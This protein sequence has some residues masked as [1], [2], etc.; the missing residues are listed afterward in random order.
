[1]INQPMNVFPN[2]SALD[3][4]LANTFSFEFYGNKLSA[5]QI[6]VQKNNTAT[7]IYTGQKTTVTKY[8]GDIVSVNLP[9]NAFPNGLDLNWKVTLWEENPD[10][11]IVTGAVQKDST[12]AVIKLRQSANIKPN[13]YL[14]IGNAERKITAYNA[15]TGEATVSPAFQTVPVYM[16]SYDIYSD[17]ISSPLY[18]FKSRTTPTLT[19][20]ALPATINLRT[21]A[22]S[23]TYLQAENTPI[24]YHRWAL[25]DKQNSI[26]SDS[27]IIY[28]AC[29]NYSFD[30][31]LS[32]EVYTRTLTIVTQ[33]DITISKSDS[34]SVKYAS[35]VIG[36]P[37]SINFEDAQGSVLLNWFDDRQS[38]GHLV[39]SYKYINNFPFSG[40]V[41][42]YLQAGASL[43]YDTVSAVPLQLKHGSY[44]V[45]I[46]TRLDYNKQGKIIELSNGSD[47]CY[48]KLFNYGFYLVENGVEYYLTDV[49]PAIKPMLQSSSIPL[50]DVGYVWDDS[51]IF[52]EDKFFVESVKNVSDFQY[53][54]T[55]TTEKIFI[56]QKSFDRHLVRKTD[57]NSVFL[58]EQQ[59]IDYLVVELSTATKDEIKQTLA[60]EFVPGWDKFSSTEI[61]CTF[62]HNAVSTYISGL[63]NPLTGYIVY[64]Q[65]I[66]ENVLRKIAFVPKEQLS[67]RDY[68]IKS[69]G[70]YMWSVVPTT[71]TEIGSFVM[72]AATNTGLDSWYITSLEKSSD[73]NF[74]RYIP[75]ETWKFSIDI[76]SGDLV[77]NTDKTQITN[78]TKYP[79][80]SIGQ[81]NF[82]SGHLSTLFGNM[83]CVE[84]TFKED[85]DKLDAWNDF[86][87]SG[88]DCILKDIK[89][90]LMRVQITDNVNVVDYSIS[91]NPVGVSF[92]YTEVGSTKD[93]IIYERGDEKSNM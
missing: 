42:L 67:L 50:E 47:T 61:V 79:K 22:F 19:L 84:A 69:D 3:G 34:F 26:V 76:T 58:Y 59:K 68:M 52:T 7:A 5:Y 10:I 9:K 24:K 4:A 93:M 32:G 46:S 21:V 16:D 64:R 88:R 51:V 56:N 75:L 39:G 91:G 40:T 23:A 45:F 43:C 87:A 33:D 13:M 1:M 17:Y 71:A 81:S 8:N 28:S 38:I 55:I 6:T 74:D 35:P 27:G 41:S 86:V 73:G 31:L 36:N 70:N 2:N 14:R 49:F 25:T 37:P 18:F 85:M 83:E 78:Y 90:N 62:N 15:E 63:I 20:N 53:K 77:Q 57:Y 82:F 60:S 54:I 44:S 65:S 48:L 80:Y 12:A 66:K 11:F 92:D 89:G 30:G 29:L 72:S